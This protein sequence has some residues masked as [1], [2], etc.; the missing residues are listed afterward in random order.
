MPVL[1]VKPVLVLTESST[2]EIGMSVLRR[3][4]KCYGHVQSPFFFFS[5]LFKHNTER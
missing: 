1:T 2:P 4:K 3:G 5:C